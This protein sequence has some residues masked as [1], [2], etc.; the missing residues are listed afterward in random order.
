MRFRFRLAAV[1][2][3]RRRIEDARALALA[4]ACRERD[5]AVAQL[6]ALEARTRLCREAV[7]VAL[8][9]GAAAGTLDL[10]IRAVEVSAQQARSAANV[11]AAA[12]AAVERARCELVEAARDRQ[13]LDR[14]HERARAR[15]VHEAERVEQKALDDVAAV[16]QR[17]RESRE[18]PAEAQP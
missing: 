11:V 3:H 2:D 16:Y 1:R 17:W 8:A 13:V 10:L 12:E 4:D 14:A 15:Y 6:N 7:A 5:V 18:S 9:G